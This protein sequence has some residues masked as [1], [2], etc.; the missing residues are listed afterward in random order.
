[1]KR[2]D[3]TIKGFDRATCRLVSQKIE[4]ALQP[5]A[6]ELGVAI[7]S[8]GGSYSGG[9][10]TLKVEVAAVGEDGSVQTKEADAFKS[11]ATLY[12]FTP[13]DLGREFKMG[14]KSYKI[15]GLRTKAPR[16]PILGESESGKM[17]CFAAAD[18][19]LFLSREKAKV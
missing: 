5:L 15:A 9:H 8:K 13:E 10:Y 7:R 3:V 19:K 18:V 6:E 14:S 12:G 1:M 17:F 4:A 16:R 2:D 11:L